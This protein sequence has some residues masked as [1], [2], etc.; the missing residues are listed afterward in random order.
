MPTGTIVQ[1]PVADFQE[2]VRGLREAINVLGESIVASADGQAVRL[3]HREMLLPRP[4]PFIPNCCQVA[5]PAGD[6]HTHLD[7]LLEF[8][9]WLCDTFKDPPPI[10][11]PA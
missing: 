9:Q 8:V 4:G 1:V 7:E 11:P 6:W 5:I 2:A 3:R 10:A